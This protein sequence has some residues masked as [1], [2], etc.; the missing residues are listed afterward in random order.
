MQ[1]SYLGRQISWMSFEKSETEIPIKWGL[2]S[3]SITVQKESVFGA[4]LVRI[5]PALSHIRTE[6]GEIRSISP[7]SLRMRGEGWKNAGQNNLEYGLFLCSASSAIIFFNIS[8][9]I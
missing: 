7:Y 3:P 2:V 8:M 5:F 1:S 9:G 6:Y 4:V